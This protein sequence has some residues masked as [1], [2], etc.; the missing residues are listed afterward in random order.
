MLV[1]T[2]QKRSIGQLAAEIGLNSSALRFYETEGLLQPDDRTASGYRV[3][4]PRAEHR[5]RFLKRAKSLGLTLAEIKLLIESP[6]GRRDVEASTL[7]GA[8]ASK[9]TETRASIARLRSVVSKLERLEAV[10]V[11]HAPP[12]CCHLGDCACWLPEPNE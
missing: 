2:T 10:L 5:L 8:V 7:R 3:Y 4:G 6:R 1:M 12:D 9:I 11:R